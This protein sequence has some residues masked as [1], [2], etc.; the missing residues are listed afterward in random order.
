MK[1][2]EKKEETKP[3]EKKVNAA[4]LYTAQKCGGCHG[5]DGKGKVKNS[6]NFAD[7]AWQKKTSDAHMIEQIK[8]GKD[9]VMPGYASKL[10]DAEIKALVGFIRSF[11][12]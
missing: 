2:E 10:S 12:K 3:A 5:A 11:A 7:P 4:A 6:P 9:P 8:K 1:A